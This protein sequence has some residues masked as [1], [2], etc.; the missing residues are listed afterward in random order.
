[1]NVFQHLTDKKMAKSLQ[2]IL[3]PLEPDLRRVDE[4]IKQQLTT[5]IK[6]LDES[7]LHLFSRGGKRIRASLVLLTSGLFG[8]KPDGIIDLAAS[9]EIVHAATLIHDDIIDR[10]LLRRGDVT[11]SEKFGSKAAVLAGDYMYTVALKIAADD[12]RSDLFPF[13]VHGTKDMV[14]GELYQLQYSNIESITEEHYYNIIKLKTASFMETC[15]SLG[16]RKA[17]LPLDLSKKL[18]LYG[19]NLGYAFQIIDDTLDVAQADAVTGKDSGNDF[20]D[21]KITLPFLYLL[22]NVD[23]LKRDELE[24]IAAQPSA[25]KWP[26]IRQMIIDAGGIDYCFGIAN[27]Y[28]NDALGILKEIPE[29]ENRT[30]MEELA[31][32]II[33]RNY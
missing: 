30:I 14:Q 31:N 28:I 3:K 15:A 5:G 6:L 2:E 12:E 11:V 33:D 25:E 13:M 23:S 26:E 20:M 16:A 27:R 1:M 22:K 8:E 32:F 4:S 9:A 10:A 21:G 17:N 29:S 18:G 7:A 24:K 19:L